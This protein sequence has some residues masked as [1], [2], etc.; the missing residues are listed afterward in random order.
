MLRSIEKQGLL[1]ASSSPT[2]ISVSGDGFFVVNENSAGTGNILFTRAGSFRT[3][4]DGNLVNTAGFYLMG[5]PITSGTVQQT[6]VLS[7]FSIVN[8]GNLVATPQESTSVSLGANLTASAVTSDTFDI[9][10]QLFDQQ[11]ATRLRKQRGERRAGSV[12]RERTHYGY[13]C[14]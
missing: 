5:W 12:R 9:G 4:K 14:T 11:G 1:E 8:V 7:A 13:D 3:D 10:V 6:N 2:D